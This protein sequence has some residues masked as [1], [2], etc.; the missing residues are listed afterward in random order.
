MHARKNM[1]ARVKYICARNI[2]I[3]K[4]EEIYILEVYMYICKVVFFQE[5]IFLITSDLSDQWSILEINITKLKNED[6]NG[7]KDSI[8]SK[9]KDFIP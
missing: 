3:G 9:V 1:Y 5:Y 8:P 6:E 7:S 4:R 2:F